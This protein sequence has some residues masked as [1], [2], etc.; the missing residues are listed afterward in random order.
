LRTN[1]QIGIPFA[2]VLRHRS[3]Y[4]RMRSRSRGMI[5]P[6]FLKFVAPRLR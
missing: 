1:A 6:S 5:C 3:N 4:A 2:K